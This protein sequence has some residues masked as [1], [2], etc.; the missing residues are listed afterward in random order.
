MSNRL[1]VGISACLLG[2]RVRYDGQHKRDPYLVDTLGKYVDFV[3]VC[4]EMECGL[5]VP[6]EAMRL[7]GSPEAPRLL[8]IDTCTDHT[9]RMLSWASKRVR[10]LEAENLSGYIFKSKSPSCGMKR[11]EVYTDRGVPTK[12]GVGLFVRTFMEHFPL[13]P[14]VEESRLHDPELR[15]A[16]IEKVSSCAVRRLS[17]SW[18]LPT[19]TTSCRG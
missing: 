5:G 13:L 12:N 7:V 19:P 17:Y 6:R 15:E 1:R 3:P 2:K 11:V 4:P 9:D 18:V 16:Y 10:E 8:T 14:V